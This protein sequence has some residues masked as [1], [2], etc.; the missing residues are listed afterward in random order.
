MHVPEAPMAIFATPPE[1][2]PDFLFS[3]D[4]LPYLDYLPN[5]T[6]LDEIVHGFGEMGEF[7]R[8]TWSPRYDPKFARRLPGIRVP[9]T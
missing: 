3:G 2:I 8:L 4:F 6:I 1:G 9:S 7:A 5:P